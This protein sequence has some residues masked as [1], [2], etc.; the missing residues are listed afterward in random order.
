MNE[1]HPT[2]LRQFVESLEVLYPEA[3]IVIE[4]GGKSSGI[5]WIDIASGTV[6]VVVQWTPTLGFSLEEV[7]SEPVYGELPVERYR[8]VELALKRMTQLLAESSQAE[9][10]GVGLR[11][12]RDLHGVSQTVLGTK[13][14]IKQAAV[15][16]VEHRS[17]LHLDTL[18]AIVQALGGTL[19]IRARFPDCVVP[20]RFTTNS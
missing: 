3:E 1:V 6:H 8:T 13:L 14:G 2:L 4:R 9:A 17:D 20:M 12:L 16:R 19:E 10:G 5:W 7:S 18:M 15:S 11:E